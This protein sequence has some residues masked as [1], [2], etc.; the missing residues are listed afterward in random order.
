MKIISQINREED[1]LNV[2]KGMA[3]CIYMNININMNK[4]LFFIS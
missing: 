1:A 3:L 2:G 4:T